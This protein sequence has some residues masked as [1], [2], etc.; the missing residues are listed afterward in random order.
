MPKTKRKIPRITFEA[1]KPI[2][3]SDEN[4]KTIEEAYGHPISG[5]VR[6]QIENV[7][8]EFLQFALAEDTGSMED[9]VQARQPVAR[10]CAVAHQGNRCPCYYRR[11]AANPMP[12]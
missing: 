12:T 9:A 1:G 11:G 5:E 3:F 7:T 2:A 6:T 4:W 8:A 10:L